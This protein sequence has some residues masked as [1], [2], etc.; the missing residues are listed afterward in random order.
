MKRLVR[1][2]PPDNWDGNNPKAKSRIFGW[3]ESVLT[4]NNIPSRWITE[5]VDDEGDSIVRKHLLSMS[6]NCCSY[7][8]KRISRECEVD[9]YLPKQPFRF[10]A[11]C[12]HNYL[13]ACRA[14]NGSKSNYIPPALNDRKIIDSILKEDIRFQG[15]SHLFYDENLFA[16]IE[17]RLFHPMFDEPS[18]HFSFET[19]ELRVRSKGS[20]IG[21][22]T[23]SRL[24]KKDRR[25]AE[26]F[27]LF[28]A[29]IVI[30]LRD[31]VMQE[32]LISEYSALVGY[33]FIIRQM[34]EFYAEFDWNN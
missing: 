31:G 28:P 23:V 21:N 32:D 5:D 9:H 11:Y 1:A 3:Y 17:E 22:T 10:V 15:D 4:S 8:G 24:F 13:P 18:E 7:C 20:L 25:F 33:E 2:N 6:R 16:T 19:L 26:E 12:W 34:I 14:C 29:Y 27:K 30:R